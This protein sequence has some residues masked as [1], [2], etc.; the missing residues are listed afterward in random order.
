MGLYY[1]S[2]FLDA[3]TYKFQQPLNESLAGS[4]K[5]VKIPEEILHRHEDIEES[6]ELN[7]MVETWKSSEFDVNFERA[8]YGSPIKTE[9]EGRPK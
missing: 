6:K 4:S 8:E 1:R 7:Q 9:V 2:D 3:S 5:F